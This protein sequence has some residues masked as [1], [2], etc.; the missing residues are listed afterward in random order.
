VGAPPT[1]Q[2]DAG[3]RSGP[4]RELIRRYYGDDCRILAVRR[5]GGSS[6][7]VF[8]VEATLRGR[9]LRLLGTVGRSREL[10]EHS[11]MDLGAPER[12]VFPYERLMLAS[13]ALVAEPKSILLLGLGGGAMCRHLDAYLPGASVTVVERDA[14]V[15]AFAREFFH[16]DRKIV[17]A[18]AEEIVADA[19]DDFDAVMVD[20]YDAGGGAPLGA[21]FWQDCVAALR[22]GGCLAINWAGGWTGADIDGTPR[23]R[24]AR[25]MPQLAGSFLVAERGPRGNIVQLAPT[26]PDFRPSSLGAQLRA[27]AARHHL[28]REDR[29]ILQR[30]DVGQ[31]YPARRQGGKLAGAGKRGGK[32]G[33]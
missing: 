33:R 28:P 19:R 24:I 13:L 23:Q 7:F 21:R 9:L 32:R 29:D 4:L 17:R 6:A 16:I 25:V 11:A 30:C 2:A 5:T 14:A 1:M 27:F 31:R 15:I 12:L 10:M 8:V 18:D 26:A 22:Q 3:V 20:L